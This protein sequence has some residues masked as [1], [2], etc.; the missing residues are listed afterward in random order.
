[1]VMVRSFVQGFGR[2]ENRLFTDLPVDAGHVEGLLH[3]LG[4]GDKA[5]EY[6]FG[7][8]EEIL[9]FTVRARFSSLKLSMFREVSL[10]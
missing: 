2:N 7:M 8:S 9:G 5:L 3:Q 1:M 10:V 6:R 4:E